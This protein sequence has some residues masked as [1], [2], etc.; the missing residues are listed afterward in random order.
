M[1][2]HVLLSLLLFASC[3]QGGQSTSN[4]EELLLMAAI[5]Q[6]SREVMVEEQLKARGIKNAAVLQ[7]MTK[8]SRASFL[9]P[10]M[11]NLAYIDGPVPI[12]EGQTISQPFIVGLMSELLAVPE[13]AKVLEIGTG[14]GYQAAILAAMG[15]EV[16]TIE[17]LPQL[18]SKA[19]ATLQELGFS[20]VQIKPGDGY[21]GWPEHAPFDGIIV[22][23]AAPRIPPKL[24]EQLKIGGKMV[25]PLGTSSQELRVFTK[26]A[27]G[28]TEEN[29]LPVRFVPMT[30]E[31]EKH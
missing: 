20:H 10:S 23:A 11:K 1:K 13:K 15:L 22:T 4:K 3:M 31:I 8:V 12:G 30:G 14:S 29:I 5:D 6:S 18:A 27:E 9:P 26:Q 19:A 17:I 24:L 25:M 28:F 16:Y 7:A 2:G 21:Q